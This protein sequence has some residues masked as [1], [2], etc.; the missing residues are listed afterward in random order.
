[1]PVRVRRVLGNVL[2]VL[3]SLLACYLL[4]ELVLFKAL[5]PHLPKAAYHNMI[6]ELRVLGQSSFNGTMPAAGFVAIAGDSNAQGKGDWFIDQG[7][8]RTARYHSAHV[9]QELLGRDVLSF[10]RSGAGSVDGLLLEP[11][12]IRAFLGRQGLELPQPSLLLAYF[13]EGNDIENNLD[14]LQRW[15]APA[16]TNKQN[17]QEAL[18]PPYLENVLRPIMAE[19]A[20]G[21]PRQWN[22]APLCGNFILRS[23][24]DTLRNVFTR[25][26]ID[27]EQAVPPGEVN[28]ARIQGRVVALP[29]RLQ[30]PPLE[31][32]NEQIRAGVAVLRASLNLLAE[33]FAPAD[34]VVVYVPAP[35]SC[36]ELVSPEVSTFY[37]ED[38]LFPTPALYA[39][40]D[41]LHARVSQAVKNLGLRC[42]DTRPALRQAAL[43][44]P[45]HGPRDWDHLNKAGYEAL[46]RAIAG[47]LP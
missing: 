17:D 20:D 36:Y 7:Y 31:Y 34:V 24:R 2:L 39:A 43:Q 27:I 25:K 42:I 14:F 8:N 3:A 18:Q 15:L 5:L 44:A 12:Q 47:A 23:L 4:L 13:Y 30:S 28:M 21:R 46:S 37:G 32:D 40:S 19:H 1:M 38:E 11:V 16:S 35:L 10:G 6:R 41:A 26:Y 9:L 22:D 29:D 45:I 33:A